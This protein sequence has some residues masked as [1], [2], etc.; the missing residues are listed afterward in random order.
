[1]NFKFF[2]IILV[3]LAGMNFSDYINHFKT[4][5]EEWIIDL[6]FVFIYTGIFT[7]RNY[8]QFYNKIK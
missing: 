4:K 3:S 5:N 8:K 1:M 6:I 7:W 2:D